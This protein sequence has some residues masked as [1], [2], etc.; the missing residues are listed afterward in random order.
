MEE[1]AISR[2]RPML[3]PSQIVKGLKALS[4]KAI[5]KLEEKASITLT[6]NRNVERSKVELLWKHVLKKYVGNIETL[7]VKR[8]TSTLYP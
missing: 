3:F 8:A 7:S 4:E 1:I 6:V 2:A 5:L